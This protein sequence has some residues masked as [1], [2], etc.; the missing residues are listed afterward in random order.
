M[1]AV[2]LDRAAEYAAKHGALSIDQKWARKLKVVDKDGKVKRETNA[3]E[4]LAAL[5]EVAQIEAVL[6]PGELP[7]E[8]LARRAS[9]LPDLCC[10]CSSPLGMTKSAI[11]LRDTR[12]L[13]WRCVDCARL[14]MAPEH[15][16]R[17]SERHASMSPEARSAHAKK[18]NAALSREQRATAGRAGC[19]TKSKEARSA[20]GRASWANATEEDRERR[21]ASARE[22][23]AKEGIDV[24]RE[25]MARARASRWKKQA[26]QND[27]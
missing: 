15:A 8:I 10:R 19:A 25:R 14:D 6:R 27:T 21:A 1:S 13:P 4:V 9:G 23:R 20:M 5:A 3:G 26:K 22:A 17:M 16:R 12:P 7:R 2:E 18:A 11:R 24:L